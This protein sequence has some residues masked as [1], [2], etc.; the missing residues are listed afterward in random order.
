MSSTT[1]PASG[2][3]GE[4]PPPRIVEDC[5]GLVQ[6]MSDGTVKRA[7]ACL[8]SADDAAP[9]R[10]KDVVYDEARNL[11]LRMY[12]PSSRAGNGGAEK[13]PVLVYFHGGGFI[14]GSFASPEFHAACARLAAALPAVVL[15]A[16]YRLAPEHRLPAALEDADAIFSW[17]GAQ[18]QQADPWLA[19]AAD[20]GRVFVSGDSAGANIAHHAAAAPGRRLAGCVLLWPFFGGERRTR[21]EAAYLGDAFLTLP[22]YDQMWRLALPAG[23]TRDH[24]AANPEAGELPPLLVA[25]GDRDMLIDRIREYVAR[26]RAAAAGNRRVDLV[27]FPGAGHGFAI[28][29]PD[30]EAASELVRVVRRF[31]HGGDAAG[32]A[33]HSGR[34]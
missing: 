24:P 6:L 4:A 5:L 23:A 22:L 26:V 7:P 34:G 12:V 8:A 9:V 19:D 13:L 21:S 14:V 27:E 29:E 10:C 28:L 2:V 1:S 33:P 18:E 15:S 30:G 32:P 25:A 3:S 20:L 16:D 11:S 17:L 31:V